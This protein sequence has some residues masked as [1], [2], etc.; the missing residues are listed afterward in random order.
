[1]SANGA[2]IRWEGG[3]HNRM[4]WPLRAAPPAA[5][6]D[7]GHD[8]SAPRTVD[9]LEAVAIFLLILV[10]IW[11]V[12]R[13]I[14]LAWLVIL[15]PV[16][17]SHWRRGESFAWLGFRRENFVRCLRDFAPLMIGLAGVPLALGVWFGT[18]HLSSSLRPL[19][20]VVYYC[21]WGTFQQYALNGFFVNRLSGAA[22]PTEQRWVPLLAAI[23][24]AAVHT[25][26]WFLVSVTFTLGLLCARIYVTYRNLFFLGI[27]HGVIGSA[28]YLTVPDW[29]SLH[30]FIGPRA[31]R[32]MA[33]LAATR[34]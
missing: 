5:S 11:F 31:L 27:A 4:Y 19:S 1:M 16:V 17:Y 14:K 21:V 29:I 10:H 26:N 33:T 6:D 32:Y 15:V 12:S 24:F 30:F 20:F 9:A 13:H 23:L 18:L 25:P 3:M 8:A 22:A 2:G 34:M 7:A 28:L